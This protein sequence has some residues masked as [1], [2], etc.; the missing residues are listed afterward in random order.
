MAKRTES[1]QLGVSA[2]KEQT[3]PKPKQINLKQ[4]ILLQAGTKNTG[5]NKRQVGVPPLASFLPTPHSHCSRAQGPEAGAKGFSQ[6]GLLVAVTSQLPVTH[7]ALE[8]GRTRCG[9]SYVLFQRALAL[10][11]GQGR[12]MERQFPIYFDKKLS[13][14]RREGPSSKFLA[15]I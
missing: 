5:L 2:K 6:R 15:Q 4:K 11:E 9:T 8:Q 13:P 1:C 12:G 14:P 3:K 7:Q 10:L